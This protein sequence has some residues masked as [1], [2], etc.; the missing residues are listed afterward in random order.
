[1]PFVKEI[2]YLEDS[3]KAIRFLQERLGVNLKVAQKIID[4]GRIRLND[5]VFLDKSGYL[6]GK[7]EI[8]Y[9]KPINLNLKPIFQT[10]DFA[11]FDKP[12]D[13]LTHPKGRFA[14]QSLLDSARF[15]LGEFANPINRLDRETS[16]ILLFSKNK[17]S[18]IRLKELFAT[19]EVKKTYLAYVYGKIDD[20][21]ID[22]P[23]STQDRTKDLGIR[24]IISSNA[25]KA[26]TNI[27]LISYD[28]SRD[29]SLIKAK[30]LTGR[31]HQIRLHLSHIGHRILGESL[32]GVRDDLSRAYLDG[33]IEQ[34][35]RAYLFGANRLM[36]HSYSL[37][38]CYQDRRYIL[39]SKMDF[40]VL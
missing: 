5:N 6:C 8:S 35:D 3:T 21:T 39:N 9:F 19:R 33:K 23:I 28:K 36:L 17:Q 38:F 29:I 31:T 34:K 13:L 7:V 25:K 11:I 10:D 20:C 1:M 12:A 4:K 24:S 40:E 2:L 22:L 14:H 30:P 18:E 26:I 37:E 16:G 32:Y 15:S 27:E